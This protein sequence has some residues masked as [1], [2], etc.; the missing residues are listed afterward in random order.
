[1]INSLFPSVFPTTTPATPQNEQ[2]PTVDGTGTRA[3]VSLRQTT[4]TTQSQ[5][6]ERAHHHHHHHHHNKLRESDGSNLYRTATHMIRDAFQS[7]RQDLRDSFQNLGFDGGMANKITKGVM[8]A[9]RDALRSGVDFSAKLTFAA[10]TQVGASAATEATDAAGATEATAAT[11][12]TNAVATTDAANTTRAVAPAPLFSIVARSIEVSINHSTGTV[13]VKAASVS[14]EGQP[15]AVPGDD[16]PHLLDTS[17]SGQGLSSAL[18]N[19]LIALQDLAGLFGAGDDS[20]EAPADG[21]GDG[22]AL[23]TAGDVVDGQ[24]GEPAT[25]TTLA[26]TATERAAV[27][28]TLESVPTEETT[29][30]ADSEEAE[31]APE[32][33]AEETQEAAPKE[34]TLPEIKTPLLLNDPNYTARI[35][36]TTFQQTVNDRQESLTFMRF[37]AI[38]PLS[39]SATSST[40]ETQSQPADAESSVVETPVVETPVVE[41]PV[42]ETPVVETPVVEPTLDQTVTTIV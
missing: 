34:P 36:I 30:V 27:E 23:T 6:S 24:A 37:D 2:T 9:T 19:V 4:V 42:V 16:Q 20:V 35:F 25:T 40:N 39:S 8:H 26:E 11:D 29:P 5:E 7:F 18:N 22:A 38:I 28:P 32:T 31:A 13:D 3:A 10:I 1:M 17:D 21:T 14:I 41:T 12:A 33:P 15:G